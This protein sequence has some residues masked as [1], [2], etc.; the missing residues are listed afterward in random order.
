MSC[1]LVEFAMFMGELNAPYWDSSVQAG[2]VGAMTERTT[3]CRLR[4]GTTTKGDPASGKGLW[5]VRMER[6][7]AEACAST[8]LSDHRR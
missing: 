5:S 6:S 2:F 4:C 8:V 1:C 7:V 3:K